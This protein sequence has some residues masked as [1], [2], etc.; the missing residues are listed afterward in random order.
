MKNKEALRK[1]C[2]AMINQKNDRES[3]ISFL[4]KK[5]CEKLD[6]ILILSEA[7]S[8]KFEQAKNL[9]HFSKTWKDRR[10]K[11]DDLHDK[12]LDVLEEIDW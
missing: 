11:D 10:E 4:R 12:I 3:I 8:L 2:Q 5:G 7:T 1:T 6:S 9:V